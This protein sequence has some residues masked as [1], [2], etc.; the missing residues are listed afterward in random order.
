M[1]KNCKTKAT[2]K[3]DIITESIFLAYYNTSKNIINCTQNHNIKNHKIN[4]LLNSFWPNV[5]CSRRNI[6]AI[7]SLF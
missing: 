4:T 3:T 2:E 1:A 6:S 5:I 7:S